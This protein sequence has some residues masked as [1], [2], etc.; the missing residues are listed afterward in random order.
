MVMAGA[1]LD[2]KELYRLDALKVKDSKLLTEIQ[3][4][5]LYEKLITFINYKIVIILPQEIDD[6]L[7]SDTLNLNWMEAIKSALIIN[8]L[9]PSQAIID[10][11]SNNIKKYT[12]YLRKHLNDK[13]LQLIVEHKADF[14]HKI[15]A[16]ASILAKV[17]RDWEIRKLQEAIPF[18]L[19]SG[20]PSDPSTI[21]F[22]KEHHAKYENIIRKSWAPYQTL[23]N[24]KK[25]KKLGEF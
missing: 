24:S 2:E 5:H 21:T 22:L 23:I 11:P 12:E 25:Q 15:V 16:A 6:A 1:M 19:G 17:T 18:N 8:Q 14:N 13:K 9:K 3:R 20:Y 7:N 10:C 4:E